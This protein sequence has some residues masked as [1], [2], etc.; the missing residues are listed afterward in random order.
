SSA[1]ASYVYKRHIKHLNSVINDIDTE[2]AKP[3]KID[4]WFDKILENYNYSG[5]VYSTTV[6]GEFVTWGKADYENNIDFTTSLR[7]PI[8]S[9]TTQFTAYCIIRF[10]ELG[11]LCTDDPIGKYFPEL[12]YGNKVTIQHLLDMT[13]GFTNELFDKKWFS[14]DWNAYCEKTGFFDLPYEIQICRHHEHNKENCKPKSVSEIIEAANFAPLKFT[15]GEKFYWA[16]INYLLLR[17]IL[18][19]VSQKSLE[20]IMDEY[21]FTPLEMDNTTLCGCTADVIGYVDN[22]RIEYY[23][24]IYGGANDVIS[25]IDDLTKW[26]NFLIKE[27]F[28]ARYITADTEFSCGWYKCNNKYYYGHYAKPCEVAVEVQFDRDGEFCISVMNKRPVPNNHTRIMYYPIECDDGYFKVEIWEMFPNSEIKVNSIKVFDENAEELYSAKVPESGYFFTLR[29][30]GEKR[31]AE[32]FAEEG[33]Y[34]YEINLSEILG[35]KFKPLGK[36]I[37]EIRAECTEYSVYT[38][39]MLGMVYKRKD[40]WISVPHNVFYNYDNAYDFFMEAL[41]NTTNFLNGKFFECVD[42]PQT[43]TSDK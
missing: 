25:T 43:D 35:S 41:T 32:E 24:D 40:E 17:I 14:E 13:S 27:D 11:L 33:S 5:C 8:G 20:K 36:Y 34:C 9:I 6:G 31:N 2:L 12:I 26:Y 30:D 28:F 7:F 10:Q 19:K 1:A 22:T 38:H 42:A 37:A 18:E 3:V 21:I 23:N 39:A 29:N 15:P 4:N 16:E